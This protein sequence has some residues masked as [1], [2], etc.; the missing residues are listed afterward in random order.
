MQT[1]ARTILIAAGIVLAVAVAWVMGRPCG[2]SASRVRPGTPSASSLGSEPKTVTGPAASRVR[3]RPGRGD[4]G[5]GAGPA[6]GYI[7]GRVVFADGRAVAGAEVKAIGTDATTATSGDGAFLLDV[8]PGVHRLVAQLEGAAGAMATGVTVAR[9]QTVD[10]I[11]IR[12]ARAASFSG[13]ASGD[14]G[15][16]VAGAQVAAR[17]SAGAFGVRNELW[18]RIVATAAA[19]ANGAFT[20]APL[21]PGVYSLE[22]SAPGFMEGSE[23][24][25][26]L[27][28]G[29][30]LEVALKLNRLGAV[31]GVVKD[32][33]GAPIIGSVVS[34]WDWRGQRLEARSDSDGH[35]RIDGVRPERIMVAAGH[36]D[37]L[38]HIDRPVDVSPGS[39]AHAD[40]TLPVTGQLAGIVTL[41]SGARAPSARVEFYSRA[42]ADRAGDVTTDADGQYRTKLLPGVYEVTASREALSK[43]Q[44]GTVRART[45]SELNLALVAEPSKPEQRTI[46]GVVLDAAGRPARGAW[47]GVR[48]SDS[49]GV[50]VFIADRERGSAITGEDGRFEVQVFGRRD[51]QDPVAVVARAGGS[52][53][54]V[55]GVKAGADV[56]IQLQL[57]ATVVG[58][59]IGFAGGNYE[60]LVEPHELAGPTE[61]SS[62]V[63]FQGDQF[64]LADLA[65]VPSVL[66]VRQA[67]H[68]ATVELA[69][70][71]G[72]TTEVD[73]RLAAEVPVTGR[74]VDRATGQPVTEAWVMVT[75]E[76]LSSRIVAGVLAMKLPPGSHTLDF[77]SASYKSQDVPVVV[78]TDPLN[79]GD[80]A[81]ERVASNGGIGVWW[82]RNGTAEAAIDHVLPGSPAAVAGLRGGDI[83]MAVNGEPVEGAGDAAEL[84]RGPIGA[85]VA[86][87]V[88]RDGAELTFQV[89]R[90]DLDAITARTQ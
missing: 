33:L 53:G 28:A 13:T 75:G 23:F 37:A 27:E 49:L 24:R 16:R 46:S 82:A 43:T 26:A 17:L 81:L 5:E 4:E 68:A 70:S 12:L 74:L 40:F 8:K 59:A 11:V 2:A 84:I 90:G 19:D 38:G 9:S 31:E 42:R 66:R 73:V 44:R 51:D 35:Y 3:E 87:T 63:Q 30:R 21:A 25:L 56:T 64:T 47:V 6:T 7:A 71:P 65:P 10:G 20:I 88:K 57:A 39:T 72:H 78:G 34:T 22:A 60:V 61:S 50:L 48:R 83:I 32:E 86:I 69:L 62:W 89:V 77:W 14:D 58:H 15:S 41:P 1:A 45:A 36:A 54:A 29:Q 80:I 76:T 55:Q 85:P 18:G 67:E 52:F 79:L